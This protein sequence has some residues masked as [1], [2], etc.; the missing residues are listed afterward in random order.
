MSNEFTH[1]MPTI[2]AGDRV[3]LEPMASQA[4]SE[5]L[6]F[7]VRNHD[8]LKKF[9]P[10]TPTDYTT[11]SYW[12]R[13]IWASSQDWQN[14]KVYRFIIRHQD[15]LIGHIN[16]SQVFRGPFQN[17]FLG[18]ALD[19]EFQGQGLMS[20]AVAL[21]VKFSFEKL[22][23][24]RIQANTLIDNIGSQKVLTK[25]NFQKEG[26]AKAYLEINGKWQDHYM[27]ALLNEETDKGL[28]EIKGRRD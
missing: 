4:V 8:F 24:H 18:Y 9:S 20:E 19:Q 23:L 22:K 25:N 15:R 21:M 6:D 28:K 11:E 2:V 14:D 12:Q 27:F 16:L 7:I 5:V 10:T 13:K 26:H 17:A 3:T 1:P